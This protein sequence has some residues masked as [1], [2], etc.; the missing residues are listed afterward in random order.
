LASNSGGGAAKSSTVIGTLIYERG[1][2]EKG[3]ILVYL[4]FLSLHY[5]DYRFE[6]ISIFYLPLFTSKAKKKYS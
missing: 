3:G 1:K 6:N 4:F 2:L 5:P